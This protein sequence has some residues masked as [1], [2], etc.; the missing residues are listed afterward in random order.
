M[1][2][3][4]HFVELR[5]WQPYRWVP[6]HYQYIALALILIYY[7]TVGRGTDVIQTNKTIGWQGIALDCGTFAPI[8]GTRQGSLTICVGTWRRVRRLLDFRGPVW[9]FQWFAGLV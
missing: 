4:K 7:A 2:G 9:E 6:I 5:M 8:N 3:T 1:A